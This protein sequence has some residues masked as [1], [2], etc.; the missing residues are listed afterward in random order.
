MLV[1]APPVCSPGAPP[2]VSRHQLAIISLGGLLFVAGC[3]GTTEPGPPTLDCSAVSPVSLSVGDHTIIDA[4]QKSCLR[5]PAAGGGGAEYLYVA[6]AT[7]GTVNENGV[8]ADYELQ[9]TPTASA[10]VASVARAA[11]GKA[12]ASGEAAAFH[13]RLRRR[14]RAFA[15][16]RSPVQLDRGAL[17][18]VVPIPPAVGDQ[19]PFEVC[20]TTDCTDFVQSTATA[21]VVVPGGRVAIFLDDNVPADG[22]TQADLDKVGLLFDTQLYPIDTTAFGRESDLDNNGVV[23]VLLTPRVNALAPT[24]NT[25]GTVILGYFY[26]LDLLPSEPH[27]NAGEV[28]YGLVP[29]PANS[30]CDISREFA[31]RFLPPVFIHEFQHMISFNQHVLVRQGAPEATWLNEG[32]S[33]F[34]E[35]LGGRL[36]PDAECQ[37]AFTAC[38]DQFIAGNVDNANEYLT[39]TESHFLIEPAN[40]TG[41]LA[42]RGANWLFVRWLA[43]H[44]AATQPTGREL[45][46]ALVRTSREGAANVEAV[47]GADFSTLVSQWQ[48]ANYLDDLPGFTPVSDRLRYTSFNFRSIYQAGYPLAPDVAGSTTYSRSGTLRGG[49]GRHVDIVQPAGAGEVTILLTG[50]GGTAVLPPSVK[51]RAVLARIR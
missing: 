14:E 8:T 19:R 36:I 7:D 27:S 45:T 6:L 40:S 35:E 4:A 38:E 48:L 20:A 18:T 24:C 11:L 47:T 44:F 3:G 12:G 22:Y 29:D 51:P 23:I 50:S 33:H 13:A 46:L 30:E 1:F 9:G 43:D 42:E 10:G 32:L 49:S 16:A 15:E 37:P 28:F 2:I 39:D 31:T 25:T 41:T 26:G 17:P 34:A 5:L 21:K